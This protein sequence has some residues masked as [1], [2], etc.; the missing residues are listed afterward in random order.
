MA[1][2][3]FQDRP[4]AVFIRAITTGHSNRRRTQAVDFENLTIFV[5]GEKSVQKRVSEKVVRLTQAVNSKAGE[6]REL[7]ARIDRLMVGELRLDDVL[8]GCSRFIR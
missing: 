8:R 4:A 3:G 2:G 6:Y 7:L 5:P 1:S